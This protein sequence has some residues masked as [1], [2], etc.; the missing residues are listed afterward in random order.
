MHTIDKRRVIHPDN[1]RLAVDHPDVNILDAEAL[2]HRTDLDGS[3][4][5]I[6][7]ERRAAQGVQADKAEHHAH[8]HALAGILGPAFVAAVAYVD[9][10][11][12]AANITSG[13]RYG[14]LLV[15]VLVLANAMSVLIQYQSAKLGIVTGKSLPE[16]LGERMS[17]A[18]RFMFFAQAEVIAIATDLAELIGGAIALNLLFGLPLFLGGCVIGAVSTVLLMFEGGKTHRM[19]EKMVIALLLVITF[20]F[21]AGLFIDPPNP[22]DV[23]G[24][25]IP[26]FTTTDSVLMASSMLG[27]TVM[28]HAIYLHSTLVNDHYAGGEAKPSIKRLLD[29]SKVDVFWALLLAGTVNLSLLILAANS[30]YGMKGT[31]SIE[32]AQHAIVA[33][34]GP[35]IG[36]IF[37]IGLLASSLSSTSVGTYAG[38]EIMHGLLRIKAPMWA[39]RVV[40]LVP[41]LIVLW[42]APNP[43]EALVVGQ[44]IL[45][46]GIPFAIIPLMRYTHDKTLM[47]EWVDGAVK[48]AIFIVVAVLIIA[49]NVLLIVLT[50]LG[51][52]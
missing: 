9:P 7:K 23:A 24:G 6:D 52:A 14:Y 3:E 49:L 40:T 22:A 32:G 10:G 29:G 51:K 33:V 34:L 12:V 5:E 36:T 13:A 44:V 48:H 19:F 30:L 2:A 17:D 47:G 37:S 8:G 43:T 26:H 4:A 46:I 50:A 25:L 20:G 11:N 15:W 16:L 27:A 39:C 45:S 18:G 28:P 42:F 21:I 38:S 41:G 1:P 35:V 31:D